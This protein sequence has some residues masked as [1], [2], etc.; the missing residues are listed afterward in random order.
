MLVSEEVRDWRS[1]SIGNIKEFA[2]G[3]AIG[4]IGTA[5]VVIALMYAA[6]SLARRAEQRAVEVHKRGRSLIAELEER[7][8]G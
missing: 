8:D 2:V 1:R 3:Y 7:H 5:V 4:F 6:E